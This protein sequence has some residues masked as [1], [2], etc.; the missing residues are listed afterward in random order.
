M[1]NDMLRMCAARKTEREKAIRLARIEIWQQVDVE[2][3]LAIVVAE[4]YRSHPTRAGQVTLST[5]L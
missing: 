2:K 3:L 1:I 5:A 4:P